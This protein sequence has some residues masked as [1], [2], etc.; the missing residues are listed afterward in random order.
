M[1]KHT[2]YLVNEQEIVTYS[3]KPDVPNYQ[4][5]DIAV[6][7]SKSGG[8][9]YTI[10]AMSILYIETEEVESKDVNLCNEQEWICDAV[11]WFLNNL[12]GKGDKDGK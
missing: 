8:A 9:K 5:G 11:S 6:F 12:Y 3:D 4:Y 7:V 1:Y 10:P 2:F